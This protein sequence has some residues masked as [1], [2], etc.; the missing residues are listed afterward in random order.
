MMVVTF[1]LWVYWS[2]PIYQ[3]YQMRA[4]NPLSYYN[5]LRHHI[6]THLVFNP[7]LCILARLQ[8]DYYLGGKSMCFD[9]VS[10]S[11]PHLTDGVEPWVTVRDRLYSRLQ[12]YWRTLPGVRFLQGRINSVF[13][14]TR[15]N[16][17]IVRFNM[18]GEAGHD[19][20][21]E[22]LWVPCSTNWAI[23]PTCIYY[24]LYFIFCQLEH[25]WCKYTLSYLIDFL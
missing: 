13:A 19:P 22:E 18:V 11:W 23:L 3:R 10:L 24:T 14:T 15:Y 2:G 8:I 17:V 1:S 7:R 12:P 6:E 20:T 21:T 4:P 16:F 5:T 25:L 9:I